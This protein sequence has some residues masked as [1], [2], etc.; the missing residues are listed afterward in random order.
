MRAT[1]R[2]CRRAPEPLYSDDAGHDGPPE[3]REGGDSDP[4]AVPLR[5]PKA[6]CTSACRAR[7]PRCLRMTAAA[8]LAVVL[9][10]GWLAC[11]PLL[12]GHLCRVHEQRGWVQG[13][14]RRRPSG[15]AMNRTTIYVRLVD[16]AVDVWRPVAA[17]AGVD[18]DY[19]IPLDAAPADGERWEFSPGD[20]L[21][22]VR[23]V[24][25]HESVLV[26]VSRRHRFA[27]CNR[28]PTPTPSRTAWQASAQIARSTGAA[29]PWPAGHA[30]A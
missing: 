15:A 26:A 1:R 30:G 2:S 4:H 16:D 9:R 21:H 3:H 23:T 8:I 10:M 13:R 27:L 22:C 5:T 7:T 18:G 17:D 11:K 6:G 20:R 25:D 28:R 19:T 29:A 24:M 12:P 14:R